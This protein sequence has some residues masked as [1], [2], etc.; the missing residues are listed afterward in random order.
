MFSESSMMMS[1]SSGS[2]SDS[3]QVPFKKSACHAKYGSWESEL[4]SEEQ[5]ESELLSE[6]QSE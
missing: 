4:L 5:S 1:E 3:E 6:E 2:D